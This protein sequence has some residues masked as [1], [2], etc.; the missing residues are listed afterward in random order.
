MK[1]LVSER[2]SLMNIWSSKLYN[3]IIIYGMF[4]TD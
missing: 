1:S 2:Q 4:E 3:L